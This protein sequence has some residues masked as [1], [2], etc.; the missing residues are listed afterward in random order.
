[1]TPVMLRTSLRKGTDVPTFEAGLLGS[2]NASCVT[3]RLT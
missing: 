1:M 3:S 2:H